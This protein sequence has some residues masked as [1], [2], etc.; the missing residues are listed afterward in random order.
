[1]GSRRAR[2]RDA[3]HA[4]QAGLALSRAFTIARFCAP[5]KQGPPRLSIV[6]LRFANIGGDSEQEST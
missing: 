2:L 3:R 4:V 1:M 6:V 5:K